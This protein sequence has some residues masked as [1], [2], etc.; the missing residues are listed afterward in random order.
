MNDDS[1]RQQNLLSFHWSMFF[2]KVDWVREG[3]SHF[4]THREKC[5]INLGNP[6]DKYLYK[7]SIHSYHVMY[8]LM[9]FLSM[10]LNLFK[11]LISIY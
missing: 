1:K 3:V 7:N 10:L 8:T 2:E 4:V 9:F 6:V 11:M 5:I